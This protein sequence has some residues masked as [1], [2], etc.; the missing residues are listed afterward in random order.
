MVADNIISPK[1]YSTIEGAGKRAKK[2]SAPTAH[3]HKENPQL[4]ST[5]SKQI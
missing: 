2:V 3:F 4:G 5:V 1:L